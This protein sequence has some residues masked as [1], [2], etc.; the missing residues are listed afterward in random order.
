MTVDA[1]E[2]ETEEETY[3]CAA[4]VRRSQRRFIKATRHFIST[5]C[6]VSVPA[7]D[8]VACL[9]AVD[10]CTIRIQHQMLS[11]ERVRESVILLYSFF[12]LVELAT[13]CVWRCV[14]CSQDVISHNAMFITAAFSFDSFSILLPWHTAFKLL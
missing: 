6:Q 5:T 12:F 3:R 9:L 7:G 13:G 2:I 11:T 14:D 4:Q 1:W 10:L 8:V